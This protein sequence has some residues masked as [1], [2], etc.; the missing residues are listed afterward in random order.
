MK[1]RP[2]PSQERLRELF[3]YCEDNISQPFLWKIRSSY[4]I[5]I[6]DI[7]GSLRSKNRGYYTI[8]FG[9]IA[10]LLHRLVWIY[11]NGDI[12]DLMVIDHIDGDLSNNRIENLRLATYSANSQNRKINS[13]NTSGVKG[14]YW[15]KQYEKWKVQIMID[16]KSK[17]LGY[18]NTIEEAEAAVIAA[19]NNLH[20]DFARHE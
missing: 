6:G 18:Y 9:G 4:C 7:A 11:H 8:R 12:P 13:T 17:F 20:G 3:E 10:Y 14:V 2:H 5:K 16:R 1:S 15:Y 19:R